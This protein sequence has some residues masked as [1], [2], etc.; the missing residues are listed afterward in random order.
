MASTGSKHTGMD[1]KINIATHLK[2]YPS[3]HIYTDGSYKITGQ[4]Y[5]P[6][7]P[8]RITAGASI[9]MVPPS[10]D[11]KANNDSDQILNKVTPL[12]CLQ[13]KDGSTI[14]DIYLDT[15]WVPPI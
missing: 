12:L 13:I 9:I 3:Y 14:K 6:A 5:G 4:A 1:Q 11:W 8:D 7:H 2:Q 10:D 15:H